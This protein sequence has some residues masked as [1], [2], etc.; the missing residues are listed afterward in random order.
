MEP[1]SEE[2]EMIRTSADSVTLIGKLDAAPEFKPL[3]N[4]KMLILNLG[5]QVISW[6][7]DELSQRQSTE[8]TSWHRVISFDPRIIRRA[9]ELE[10]D[11]TIAVRGYL[12]QRTY[13]ED[14]Q[15]LFITEFVAEELNPIRT[16]RLPSAIPSPP[17]ADARTAKAADMLRIT[18][19]LL[20]GGREGGAVVISRGALPISN[21]ADLAEAV[22]GFDGLLST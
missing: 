5:V 3:A 17:P 22:G 7:A 11:D 15:Q 21:V 2:Q 4:G 9:H 16:K 20:P 18:V 13:D 1:F 14:G 19:E 8:K 6:A 10:K 12:D